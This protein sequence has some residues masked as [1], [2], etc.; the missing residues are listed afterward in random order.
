LEGEEVSTETLNSI[1][2]AAKKTFD[3]LSREI[4]D[5]II[6]SNFTETYNPIKGYLDALKWDGIG[7]VINL[8]LCITSDTGSADFRAQMLSKWMLG[9][10]ESIYTDEPNILC[11]VLAGK[12][13]TGK[14]WF[15]KKLLPN[16]LRPYFASSQMDKGKDDE[17]LMCQKLI[18][19]DDEYSGKSKQDSK[20]MKMLLSSDYF[21][22]REPYGKKNIT[23]RRIATMCGTCNELDVLN[24]PTG[25]RRVIVFEVTGKFAYANYN[26]IDK[27]QVLAELVARFKEGERS[28]LTDLE[29]D[30]LDDATGAKFKEVSAEDEMVYR[31]FEPPNSRQ[32]LEE[33][34]TCTEIK[35]YIETCSV[36]KLSVKK[37]GMELKRLGYPWV[38]KNS[39]W[40]YLMAKTPQRDF[41]VG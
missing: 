8:S 18:I 17:I 25:N 2:I 29:I 37:L 32:S 14:T 21:T 1:F 5:T 33:F 7:R 27:E 20:K 12:K 31:F 35:N 26:E 15:F 24:D 23:I 30:Q 16:P 34:M 36:Q 3:K 22:L 9:I 38:A 28:T 6:F 10:I 40:G 41:G 4:F 11:L 19:F 39:R 13:N